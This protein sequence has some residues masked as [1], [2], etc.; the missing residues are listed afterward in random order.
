MKKHFTF[1]FIFFLFIC[2]DANAADTIPF[3]SLKA[4][5]YTY[6]DIEQGLLIS[7]VEESFTDPK[8]RLWVNPCREQDMHKAESF[9][10]FDG[11]KSYPAPLPNRLDS[12][13][14]V[15]WF[16]KGISSNGLIYGAN[17]DLTHVFIFNP[18]TQENQIY[19]VA[20]KEKIINILLN[21]K[22]E[23][24]VLAESINGY[25]IY[26]LTKKQINKIIN[27][28]SE[29]DKNQ[30]YFFTPAAIRGQHLVFLKKGSGFVKYNMEDNRVEIFS[31][32]DFLEEN[33][34]FAKGL[35]VVS[36]KNGTF[37]FYISNHTRFYDYDIQSGQLLPNTQLNSLIYLLPFQ[38]PPTISISKDLTGNVLFKVIWNKGAQDGGSFYQSIFLLDQEGAIFNY[39]PALAEVSKASRYGDEDS[40]NATSLEANYSN[41]TDFKK[42]CIVTT[43]GGLMAIEIES[44]LPLSTY[45]RTWSSRG[46]TEFSKNKIAVHSDNGLFRYVDLENGTE[47]GEKM[48]FGE[49]ICGDTS[50]VAPF[51]QI[52]HQGKEKIWF[53][54]RHQLICYD[55]TR[56]TCTQYTFDQKFDK[57]AFLNDQEVAL[58]NYRHEL[59]IYNI[60]TGQLRPFNWQERPLNIGGNA[61]EL[62]VSKDG[63]LWIASLNGLWRV[64]PLSGQVV[65]LN[66]QNGLNDKRVVCIHESGDGKLWLGLINGGLQIYDPKNEDFLLIDQSKGL[67]NNTVV[68]ILSD[69][70]GDKWVSTFSGI[71]VLS[72][73]GEILLKL[74]EKDGL[75]HKEFNRF[76]SYKTENGQLI[77]GTVGGINVLEPK[78]IKRAFEQKQNLQ[79]YLTEISFFDKKQGKDTLIRAPFKEI[80]KV[81][82][83]P[84]HRYL[85]LNFALSDYI[86]A[87]NSTFAYQLVNNQEIP[88]EDGWTSI[89]NNSDLAVNNLPPG[90]HT[91]LIRG[92]DYKGQ[93][94]DEMIAVPIRV[95]KFFYNTWWFY[96]LCFLPFSVGGFL[97]YQRLVT[98]KKRLESEVEKRTQKIRA[99]KQLIEQ[100]ALKLRELDEIKSRFFTNISHE[101]RTPL[102]IITGMSTQ[103][104][105]N[106][107]QWLGKGIELIKRNSQ[108]LLSLINQILDLRKLESGA[109]Q[110]N[111]IQANIISYLKYIADSFAP[112][113]QSN[114]IKIHFLSNLSGLKMDYDPDKILH[115]LSNLLSNAIKYTPQ[116]GDIYLQIDNKDERLM[117]QVKDTGQGISKE[118]LPYIFDRFYQVKD[119]ANQKPQGSGVGL[120]LTYELIQLL[121]GSITVDSQLNVG[122]LF[123]LSFPITQKAPVQEFNQQAVVANAPP[124]VLPT[125]K[126]PEQIVL[127]KEVLH[128]KEQPVLNK[129]LKASDQPSLLI[130]ED[131]EDVRTYLSSCLQNHFQLLAAENGQKGIDLALEQVPDLIVS[132]VMM[133]VKDGFELCATLKNDKR[134]SHIPIVMLT[135][136]ADFESKIVGLKNKADAYLTKPFQQEEL[137]LTLNNLLEIRRI[138]QLKYSNASFHLN[139]KIKTGSK[140]FTDL[141]DAFLQKLQEIV[142]EQLNNPKLSADFICRKMGMSNTNFYR[143]LKALTNLS[144]VHYIRKIRLLKAKELLLHSQL[145]ITEIAYEVGFSDP[146]Y[147]SR[148]FSETFQ[149]SPSDFRNNEVV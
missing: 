124:S 115:I 114:G 41:S 70:D 38:S 74:F 146:K 33:V 112:L 22:N 82:L 136:K 108:H 68:G 52:F 105:D 87:Q 64:D 126:A 7:C 6:Y 56:N 3:P 99:D 59:L 1:F 102:T 132:D 50:R 142:I 31:W 58:V 128:N 116:G 90:K 147:F 100:Q 8:G 103:I 43:D 69:E 125:I 26:S 28:P 130:V 66:E 18:D 113:A 76:S 29:Y 141:E 91:I 148:I 4:S 39:E 9:F 15:S 89:G 21:K 16:I 139:L 61:N 46:I 119:L 144:L 129:E 23:I 117:I 120:A 95:K 65:H 30:F 145:N 63:M 106:P 72:D 75:S 19:P 73:R 135:A 101:F 60:I 134:T 80:E 24:L 47:F 88:R 78:K 44:Q 35:N 48:F 118:A 12:S 97:W 127:D 11:K 104:E 13:R 51:S 122:T 27:I 94:I 45:L 20:E 55:K 25:S 98:D 53:S 84:T 49:L 2:S 36:Y 138:L 77:F 10:Q 143:K 54:S 121:G 96:L 111:L 85:S 107:D 123:R 110:V 93:L 17:L 34:E 32:T 140:A 62:F 81:I 83:P 133:P 5:A 137:L 79:L 14:A 37:T 109:L 57:F 149:Q 71:N 86:H 92:A 131:N 40:P 67:S 42:E